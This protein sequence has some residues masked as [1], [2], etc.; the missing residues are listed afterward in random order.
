M[1]RAIPPQ[2]FE[3]VF[4]YYSLLVQWC[5]TVLSHEPHNMVSKSRQARQNAIISDDEKQQIHAILYMLLVSVV[6]SGLK[7]DANVTSNKSNK[8]IKPC[9][10]LSTARG[11]PTIMHTKNTQK[12]HVTLTLD[13]WPWYSIGFWRLSRYM[14]MLNFIK[15]RA[16][17]HELSC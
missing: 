6:C 3:Y 2:N 1:L 12:T 15:L 14:L 9:S 8:I 17:V 10:R 11:S 4:T 7:L 13:L 5:T 16:V